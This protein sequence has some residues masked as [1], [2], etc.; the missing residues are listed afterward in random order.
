MFDIF[1]SIL[2]SM[3]IDI[4]HHQS[5]VL[6][7]FLVPFCGHHIVFASHVRIFILGARNSPGFPF[8]QVTLPSGM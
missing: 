3:G 2:G 8:K 5:I 4:M 6:F 1:L 7:L